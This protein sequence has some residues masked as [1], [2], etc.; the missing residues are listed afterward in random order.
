MFLHSGSTK[1]NNYSIHPDWYL[2]SDH[3]SLIVTIPIAEEYITLSK[4][5]ILKES[6]EKAV[7]V[8]KAST[9]IS[10]LDTSNLTDNIKL[11]NL[12]NLFRVRIEQT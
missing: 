6:E 3:T 10:N 8:K 12:V 1:L 4:L 7:F 2:S 5:S 11:E 9:I